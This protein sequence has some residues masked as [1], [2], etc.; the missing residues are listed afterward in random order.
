MN[1][2]RS[3]LALGLVL[4]ATLILVTMGSS[5]TGAQAA[6]EA[7]NVLAAPVLVQA[8]LPENS[9]ANQDVESTL[10][11]DSIGAWCTDTVS[12]GGHAL[13]ECRGT[14]FTLGGDTW[15]LSVYYTLDTDADDHWISNHA[16]AE[17]VVPWMQ[18]AAEAFYEQSGKTYGSSTCGKHI[19]AKIQKGGGWAGIAWWPNSCYIGLD[20]P[21]IRGNGGQHTTIHEMRHKFFQFAYTDC[22]DDWKPG[23][24]GNAD[25][26]EGD[27]DYGTSTVDDYGYFN[28]SYNPNNSMYDHGYGNRFTPYYSEHVALGASLITSPGDPD[29]LSEGMVEHMKRCEIYDDIYVE[30]ETVQALT[31]YTYEEFFMNFF[32]ANWAFEWADKATQ[33]ELYYFESE[34]P[35]VAISNMPMDYNVNLS[36]TQSYNSHTTPDKW[37]GQYYQFTPQAGCKFIMLEGDGD[38]SANL[39]WAFMAADI[40]ASTAEYS[41]WVGEDF[42][43][44]FAADGANDRVAAAVVG[45]NQE[46]DYDFTASCVNPVIEIVTPLKPNRV[47]YVGDPLSP[48]AFLSHIR[49]SSGGSPVTG[50]PPSWFVMDVEGDAVT[51][52]TLY[53]VTKGEYLGVFV[54]P[55]KAAGTTWADLRA[56][57][58]TTGICDTNTDALLYVAPGNVDMVLLHDASGSMSNVDVLGDGTRLAQA[59]IAAKLLV[60]LA[61]D[62]DYYG[63]MD[64][65]AENDP[66]GCDPDCPHDNRVIR[67]KTAFTAANLATKID[68]FQTAIDGM[69][70][71]E[72]T[73][74]GKGLEN[75][76]DM[77]LGNPTSDNNKVVAVLSDGEENINPM[78][79]DISSGLS[80]VVDTWG[81]SGDAPSALLSRIAAENGGNFNYVST[82]PGSS[83]PPMRT[84]REVLVNQLSSTLQ[85]NGVSAEQSREIA[86]ILS[87][88][89]NYLPGGLG[90]ADGYEYLHT[91]ESG[92]ARVGQ[93]LGYANPDNPDDPYLYQNATVTE[94]DDTL[95]MVSSSTRGEPGNCSDGLASR[96][97]QVLMPGGSEKEWI[98]I[99]PPSPRI[100]PPANWDIRNSSF[101]DALYVT[102]PIPGLWKIRTRVFY[103]ECTATTPTAVTAAPNFIMASTVYST[104]TLDGQILL[105]N[106]QGM[107]GDPVPI[108]GTLLQKSGAVKNALVAVLIEKPGSGWDLRLLRDDGQSNDGAAGDGMY[109]NTYFKSTN[110]G[111][112]NVTILAVVEDPHKP[113]QVL[114][115]LWKG[116]YYM[117]GEEE[118]EDDDDFPPWWEKRYPCMDPNK[119]NDSKDDYDDDGANNGVEWEH[120]TNP[121]DPDTDDGGEMD[122]SEINGFRNPHWPNDDIVRPIYNWSVRPLNGAILVQWSRPQV[123]TRMTIRVE[124][125]D[126]RGNEY[127]GGPTGELKI[128]LPDG[129]NG[130]PFSVWL[131]GEN[132]GGVGP[133]TDEETAIPKTDPD[134]PSGFL[135]INGDAPRTI[136]KDVEL[137][138]NASDI[139][140]EGLPSPGGAASVANEW[141]GDNEVSG[142]IKMR[143]SNDISGPWS[144][145][146]PL[147]SSKQWTLDCAVSSICF[148]YGQFKDAAENESLIVFD[149]I[150]RPG[151]FMPISFSP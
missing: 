7:E 35:G 84:E 51:V 41:G 132:G 47:A 76:Q 5:M 9:E 45:F 4:A 121:C 65:S 83:A 89:S 68:E 99:S 134:P 97:V 107:T 125:K 72:W 103:S 98:P 16:Q 19:R 63:I 42:S 130:D 141:T 111:A 145:W 61:R 27:A 70:A 29:Y 21:M 101:S 55:A 17:S 24:S 38:V 136:S 8:L 110:D 53:E 43:R 146:E 25:V 79:D 112:Y 137:Y 124:D 135:F 75:A 142:A 59:K 88:T 30:R 95:L 122:G 105:H 74:L 52:D 39:G 50:I 26:V 34:A 58:S 96:D 85:D 56:C 143:F 100:P 14:D 138:V 77:A 12:V 32:A 90:L 108:V 92:G 148:V 18:V 129:A 22:V 119:Y 133:W 62:G 81:F 66:P 127:E 139:L 15:T 49:V 23:Y 36:A 151:I 69:T 91:E 113:G 54:P 120:G 1:K 109:G 128:Q 80:V 93:G 40:A 78:Y 44:V 82:S 118:S 150:L 87:V 106:G 149:D 140:L 86:G 31:P 20:A 46:Y 57:L 28:N 115:R 116:S 71:R 3:V 123:Y 2:K 64:F 117:R 33:P 102:D 147:S 126:G 48:V 67:P 11:P 73:N 10:V 131:R 13:P 6:S 94:A 60:L 104:I 37:A 114:T 144:D